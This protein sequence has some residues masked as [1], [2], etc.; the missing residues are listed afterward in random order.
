MV[1]RACPLRHAGRVDSGDWWANTT[2]NLVGTVAGGVVLALLT[3]LMLRF[4]RFVTARPQDQVDGSRNRLNRVQGVLAAALVGAL[5]YT[6]VAYAVTDSM[7][8]GW[9]RAGGVLAGCLFL[10]GCWTALMDVTVAAAAWFERGRGHPVAA[11]DQPAV[12]SRPVVRVAG[13]RRRR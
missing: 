9:T 5:L 4:A 8:S 12:R 6:G 1:G 3:A 10:A 11:N 13:F 2:A 7:R